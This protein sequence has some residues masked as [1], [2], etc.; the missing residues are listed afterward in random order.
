[1]YITY[2]NLAEENN[3]FEKKDLKATTP[4]F[5]KKLAVCYV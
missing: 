3:I 5:R 2:G 1:M 4:L